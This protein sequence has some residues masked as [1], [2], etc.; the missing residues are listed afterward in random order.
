MKFSEYVYTRPNYE[1]FKEEFLQHVQLLEDADSAA[2][3]ITQVS[4]L[5]DLRSF[6]DTQ[7]NLVVIRY[8]INTNDAF[9]EAEDEYWSDY[10]PR[11]QALTNRFYQV[12]L[13]N[14]FLPELKEAFPTTL[15][16]F[17]ESELKVFH[18]DIIPLLQEENR[19]SSEYSKLVAS[20]QLPFDGQILTLPQLTPYMQSKDR[21]VRKAAAQ[22]HTAFFEQHEATFDRIY[23]DMVKVRTKI[24]QQLGYPDFV[25]LSYDR[26][27]RFDYDREMVT[28]YRK[29]ILEQVVPVA[30][31]LYERQ[32]DRLGLTELAYYDLPL[33]FLSG[34]ATPKGDHD[35]LLEHAQ[36]MY[37]E[38]SPETGAFFDFMLEH[39]LLDLKSKKGKQSGGY[40]TY[41]ADYQAPFIF[42]NFNGTSGDVDVLT[43]EAGHAFQCFESR[44]IKQPEIVFPTFESAEI[45]SMSM[46]FI[47]WPWMEGF[48]QDETQKYKFSHLGNAVQFLPYGV[49]VDHFQHEVYEHPEMTPAERKATWR[50]LEKMYNPHKNYE[51]SPAL[52]RGIYWYRQ[53]HIF[54]S[55]FY[56]IDYTL[57]QVCAFQ[58]WKR[59]QVD[60]DPQA[61]DDYLAICKV[62][63]SQTF[64]ELVAT[65]H[66]KSPFTKGVLTDVMA[67]I[68]AYLMSIPDSALN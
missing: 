44:W 65:A 10:L 62:G 66:L 40:C 36:A 7:A 1:E 25:A 8:S 11:Y 34:N 33:E 3:A 43:H 28:G 5:D 64:L 29:E 20:A 18:D 9:Y 46:E 57:A 38:L 32:A 42:A 6:I 21:Q 17:A 49:L 59:F 37:R 14:S 53:G 67:A 68:D 26:M 48:F 23:D 63:G 16:L 31:R 45:H 19:L 13:N 56:Y 54:N 35:A 4:K 55:P 60:Q 24:A 2:T 52:E 58:F 39:E 47:T 27:K 41:I 30:Q 50:K 15:F 12:L 22:T 51:D 61:W